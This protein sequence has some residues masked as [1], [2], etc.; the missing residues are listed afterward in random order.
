[1]VGFEAEGL[2]FAVTGEEDKEKR[3]DDG[4]ANDDKGPE[5]SHLEVLVVVD[6]IEGNSEGEENGE[7][8]DWK[9]VA[10]EK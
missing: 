10:I 5:K 1:M 6:D 7:D 3:A 4:E 8:G 9:K 2:V